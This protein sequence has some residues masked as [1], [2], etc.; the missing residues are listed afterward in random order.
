L[1]EQRSFAKSEAFLLAISTEPRRG[2]AREPRIGGVKRYGIRQQP[3]PF[4]RVSS[5]SDTWE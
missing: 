5:S 2:L 4:L 1:T 3:V